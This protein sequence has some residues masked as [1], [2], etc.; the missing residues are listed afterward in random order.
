MT[1]NALLNQ[2]IQRIDKLEAANKQASKTQ[3]SLI[4]VIEAQRKQIK[5]LKEDVK[6][7]NG[8]IDG[9]RSFEQKIAPFFDRYSLD[10]ELMP[11]Y[12]KVRATIFDFESKINYS[13]RLM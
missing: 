4:N 9:F 6:I 13:C 8:I 2:L 1:E 12:D 10:S 5:K 11:V 3:S 7:Q